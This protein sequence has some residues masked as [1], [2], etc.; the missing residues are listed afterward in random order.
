MKAKIYQSID[1]NKVESL[2][3]HCYR[4]WWIRGPKVI[5]PLLSNLDCSLSP[6]SDGIFFVM[7][8]L[9]GKLLNLTTYKGHLIL[10]LST[11]KIWLFCELLNDRRGL[12][13]HNRVP[14]I[15]VLLILK[16]IP[17]RFSDRS[18]RVI[19]TLIIRML[20]VPIIPGVSPLLGKVRPIIFSVF[21]GFIFLRF[22]SLGQSSFCNFG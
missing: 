20:V 16:L 5:A 6:I 4:I 15:L 22:S 21:L 18:P 12:P 8:L 13:S 11:P 9:S 7:I 19:I 10:I 14:P 1:W 17:Q 2:P 3:P